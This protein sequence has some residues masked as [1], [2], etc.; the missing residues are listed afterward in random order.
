MYAIRSYYG[1]DIMRDDLVQSAHGCILLSNL[2]EQTQK[3]HFGNSQFDNLDLLRPAEK[4]ALKI[5]EAHFLRPIK[6]FQ[7]F[8][9]F[10]KQFNIRNNFV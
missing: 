7:G 4:I 3:I 10:S 8:N 6:L 9:F 2:I 1:C 5:T